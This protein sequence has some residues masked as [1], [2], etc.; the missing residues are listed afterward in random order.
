MVRHLPPALPRGRLRSGRTAIPASAGVTAL[1]KRPPRP[2][3]PFRA[4][5][6]PRGWLVEVLRADGAVLRFGSLTR[7]VQGLRDNGRRLARGREGVKARGSSSPPRRRNLKKWKKD[8]TPCT[9]LV[10]NSGRIKR[11]RL[12]STFTCPTVCP[13]RV[14]CDGLGWIG[15]PS[16]DF[17]LAHASRAIGVGS[18]AAVEPNG[19]GLPSTASPAAPRGLEHCSHHPGGL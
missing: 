15:S 7:G 5:D 19:T 6:P 18:W 10:Y 11:W 13:W 3:H 17:H 16:R 2:P 1:P 8:A 12:A 14:F 9:S 4:P